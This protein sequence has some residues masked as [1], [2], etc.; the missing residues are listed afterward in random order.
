[1]RNAAPSLKATSSTRD[2]WC[3]VMAVGWG[4]SVV[5]PAMVMRKSK[6]VESAV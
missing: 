2:C 4:V 5:N 1:M 6:G 3:T